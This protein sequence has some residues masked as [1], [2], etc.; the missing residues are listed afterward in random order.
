M[1]SCY[2]MEIFV[3]YT[4]FSSLSVF[5]FSAVFYIF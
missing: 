3:I 2:I 1:T 5:V 4:I